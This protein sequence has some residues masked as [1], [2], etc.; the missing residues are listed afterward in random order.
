MSACLLIAAGAL[1]Q[2]WPQWRGPNRDGKVAGFTPPAKWPEKLPL[3]WKTTV[4]LGDSTPALVGDKL[5]VFTRQGG[6]EVTTCLNAADGKQAWQDKYAAGSVSGPS[7]REHPGPRSSPAVAD[8][9]VVTVYYFNEHPETERYIA[10]TIW[11][12]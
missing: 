8:G 6:D 10:A 12:A 7:S 2:D 11:R 4:G 1:A 3:K 9:K 5:Y